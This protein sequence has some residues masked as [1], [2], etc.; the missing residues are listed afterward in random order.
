MPVTHALKSILVIRFKHMIHQFKKALSLI[1]TCLAY[2]TAVFSQEHNVSA[3]YMPPT[4]PLVQENLEA[5]QDLKFGLFMHW[6]TYSQWGIVESWSLC[7][8]DEGWTQRRGEH[9]ENYF[10]YVK[11]YENLQTTFNPTDFNPEK[12]AEAAKNAG[13]K[14][15][16]F[17][18]KHHDG[19][20]MFE[21]KHS[22][23]KITDD[24]TP[25][26]KNP[27]ANVTKEIFNAF[28]ANDFKTGAYFSKP[29]WHSE[30]YWWPYFPPKD[31]NVNYDPEKYPERW[32]AFKDFTYNQIEELMTNFGKVDILWLDGGWVRPL[33]SVDTTVDWQRT[34]KTEQ[35][36]DMPRIASMARKHQPG[37]LVVDRTVP[38]EFENYVTPEQ[39]IPSEAIDVPWESCITMGN[40]FSYVPNDQ[41]KSAT[42]IIHTLIKIVS[43]GGSYLLNIAPGPNGD[44][45]QE[46]Y[47]RLEEVG[48]WLA[49]NGEGIYETRAVSMSSDAHFYYTGRKD[50]SATYAFLTLEK[51]TTPSSALSIAIPEGQPVKQVSILGSTRKLKWKATD[52]KITVTLP[53]NF[54]NELSSHALAF[55]ISHQ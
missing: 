26:S 32:K 52:G 8:E 1:F 6:G 54:E 34:I 46:A 3:N 13:M 4:D 11:A 24:K 49:A 48:E 19:F 43:R 25:F 10:D 18:T 12:W 9:A 44:W 20:A 21:T 41:Y 16:V 31:R 39:Q 50:Q 42:Q 14:Y 17:T 37:I 36:I 38:G 53:R 22:D 35:D 33:A 55:K 5:W 45:D 30:H 29:D 47:D 27:R 23:Y 28:R 40:S 7:P 15:V 51:G 2:C